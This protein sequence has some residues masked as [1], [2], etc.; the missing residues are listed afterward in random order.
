MKVFHISP[1]E[2]LTGDFLGRI[3]TPKDLHP[4]DPCVNAVLQGVV[5]VANQLIPNRD[6]SE[7]CDVVTRDR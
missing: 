3:M 7:V 1:P 6:D 4:K 5:E 2:W